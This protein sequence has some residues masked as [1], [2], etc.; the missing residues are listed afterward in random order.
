MKISKKIKKISS[1]QISTSQDK[2]LRRFLFDATYTNTMALHPAHACIKEWLPDSSSKK[3]LELGCGPGKYVAMLS[4]LGFQV[5]GVDPYEFPTWKLLREKTNAKLISNVVAEDLPFDDDTFDYA[6]CLAALLYFD[7][8]EN[9]MIQMRRVLKPGAK[10]IISSVNRTN[11]YTLRTGK[12]LDP[13]SKNLYSLQELVSVIEK[14]GFMVSKK[15]SHGFWPPIL[16]NFW[17]YLS[18]VL[19]PFSL[20]HQLSLFLKPENRVNNRIFAQSTKK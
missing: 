19:I 20:Q 2:I 15:F 8:P 10:I 1:H 17:W 5:T 14:S 11:L 3:L 9:A 7:D 4:T 16:P 6:V 12:K 13:A 18:C